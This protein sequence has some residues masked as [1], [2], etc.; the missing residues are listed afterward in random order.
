MTGDELAILLQQDAQG[1]EDVEQMPARQVGARRPGFL[2]DGGD[3]A[4]VQDEAQGL[5]MIARVA[6]SEDM[7]AGSVVGQHA[8]DGADLAAGRIGSEAS[9]DLGQ[10]FVEGAIDHA[11]LQTDEVAAD[12]ENMR[13][14][15][16][17][18]RRSVR[19][20]ATSPAMPVPAPRDERHVGFGGIAYQGLHVFLIARHHHAQRLHLKN[21]GIGTVKRQH[22]VIEEQLPLMMPLRSSRMR[23]RCCS[24]TLAPKVENTALSNSCIIERS[25]RGAVRNDVRPGGRCS[26][27]PSSLFV[28]KH[29][30]G[31]GEKRRIDF[32]LTC[33]VLAIS[34]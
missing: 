14:N 30:A 32:S 28:G 2:A 1:V 20:R 12:L 8:A 6:V 15:C 5:D 31:A 29:R 27:F 22:R 33:S 34:R 3:V 10:L 4:R 13:G 25:A 7:R 23:P 16:G 17:S 18:D 9:A 24:S 26:F 19:G 11:R 21:A